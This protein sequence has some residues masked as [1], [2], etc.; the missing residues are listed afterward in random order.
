MGNIFSSD[1]ME[2]LVKKNPKYYIGLDTYDENQCAYCLILSTESQDYILLAKTIPDK[3]QFDEE[4]NN[5]VKYFNAQK[6]VEI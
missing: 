3:K 2:N 4:V 6:I 5:L 1:K